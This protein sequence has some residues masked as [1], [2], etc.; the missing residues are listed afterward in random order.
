MLSSGYR[1]QVLKRIRWAATWLAPFAIVATVILVA[2]SLRVPVPLEENRECLERAKQAQ[3]K[4]PDCRAY[5]TIWERGFVDPVA[6]YTLWL[7]M[8]TGVLAYVGA[9]QGFFISQQIRL[10]RDEFNATHRP[11]LIVQTAKLISAGDENRTDDAI[12]DFHV[13]NAGETVAKIVRLVAI[14]YIQGEDHAFVPLLEH[15]TKREPDNLVLEAGKGVLIRANGQN[16]SHEYASVIDSGVGRIFVLGRVEYRG[17]DNVLRNSG[18]CREYSR[19]TGMW[20]ALKD[21]EYEYVY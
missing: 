10:S 3:D 7:T 16:I 9:V 18:F 19:D 17:P 1:I 11:R 2:Q 15:G 14:G 20:H 6:Y 8:F 13:V 5:E 12:I 21:S 4:H